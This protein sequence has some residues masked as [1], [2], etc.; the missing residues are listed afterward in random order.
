[1]KPKNNYIKLI[2]V[3][4][5]IVF[6]IA[7]VLLILNQVMS[8]GNSIISNNKKVDIIRSNIG[9]NIN[10]PNNI[11]NF[12]YDVESGSFETKIGIEEKDLNLIKKELNKCFKNEIT[13]PY[14]MWHFENTC[15]WWDLKKNDVKT[16]YRT[17]V[18]DGDGNIDNPTYSHDVWAFI[19]KDKE[20]KYYLYISY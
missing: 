16:T 12:T 7:I 18:I 6:V 17:Y 3:G 15:S 1:M 11:I 19:S 13:E 9:I 8:N 10:N 4:I 2:F 14:D 5:I 20:D